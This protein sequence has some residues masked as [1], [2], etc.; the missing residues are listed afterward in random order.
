MAVLALATAA[1]LAVAAVVQTR[2][3]VTAAADL[4][5]LAAAAYA[6]DGD[7]AACGRAR[8][9]A[10]RMGVGIRYCRLSGW[11]ALIEVSAGPPGILG[12][13]GEITEHARA[14]PVDG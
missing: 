9:V 4:A 6:P 13:L 7:V 1:I 11:D 12:P 5:A 10:D 14:G 2:H 3:R 8:W